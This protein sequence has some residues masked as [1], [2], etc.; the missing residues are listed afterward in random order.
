MISSQSR[1]RCA[2]A[3]GLFAML[4]A[5][6]FALALAGCNKAGVEQSQVIARVNADDIS[7]HQLN[8]AL[9]QASKAPL[10][11]SEREA[12]VE[13][14]IDRQLLQQQ[15]LLQKLDRRPEVMARLEEARIDIL[16]A[17]YAEEVAG[18]LV[19][20]DESVAARYFSEHPA[21]F[22]ARKVYRLR[23]ISIPEDSPVN[24]SSIAA[25]EARLKRKEA[26]ADVIAWL[27]Q[28]PGRFFEQLT[29][30]PAEDLPM[31][32]AGRLAQLQRGD[33]F[34][35]RLS[36]A[37]LIYEIQSFE[38][39]PLT[40]KTAAPSIKIFLKNQQAGVSVKEELNRLRASA[41]ISKNPLP[42]K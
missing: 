15:A 4:A 37:L 6:A 3:G 21:L 5:V 18:K 31:E 12:L 28:Q 13:K 17:A 35:L 20:P 33:N 34:V 25:V 26:L 38:A 30:R 42:D 36:N 29:M 24:V 22:A 41:K 7:V 16:A 1:G 11:K 14:L 32:A 9:A 19:S 8:F 23:E 10:A 40:W 27:R 2:G 39:A